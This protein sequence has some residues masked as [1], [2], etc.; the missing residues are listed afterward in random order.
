MQKTILITGGAGYIGSQTNLYLLEQGFKTIVF[1]NLV[2]GYEEVVPKESI[3]IKGDL[4]DKNSLSEVFSNYQIDGVIHFA[5]YAYVGESV[6]DPQKYYHNNLVGTLNLLAAMKEYKVDKIVFSSTCA[7]YG[8]PET[9]PITENTP[10]RP[11]NP[12][13]KTKLMIEEVFKD[14]YQAYNLNSISL[15]YFN[16]CGGDPLLRTGELHDPETH[17]IPLVLEAA[18]DSSK[19]IKIFGD[20]YDTPDGTCVRDYIHTLDLASAHFKALQKLL[21]GEQ[22]CE[23]VNLGTGQGFSVKEIIQTVEKIT[24]SK[25]QSQVSSRRPGDPD[26]LIADIT[27][28][29]SF[30]G[31]RPENSALD[32]IVST[33]W[34]W[35]NREIEN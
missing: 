9:L 26:K 31:W 25:V 6:T 23:F 22:V 28:A 20:D 3:L 13:G 5:A 12:Y 14:Y 29:N 32:Y 18:K 11:I 19:L 35:K 33:A 1:D 27:K 8:I 34:A 7:T 16:A 15:R 24:Q 2:Y 30:L 21:D 4:A 10:Q 17:L